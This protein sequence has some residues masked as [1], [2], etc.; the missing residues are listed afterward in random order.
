MDEELRQAYLKTH[1]VIDSDPPAR[2]RIGENALG[3]VQWLRDKGYRTAALLTAWNPY[4]VP[5]APESNA[6]RQ[7]QLEAEARRL[8]LACVRGRGVDQEQEWSAEESLCLFDLSLE[9]LDAWLRRYEQNAAVRVDEQGAVEL[10]WHPE[11]RAAEER[12]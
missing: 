12:K 1:Y 7:A 8:G 10:Y 9:Q 4:S 11:L 2:L 5:L 3:F 6:E